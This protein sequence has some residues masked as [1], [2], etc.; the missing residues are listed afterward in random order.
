MIRNIRIFFA[1]LSISTLTL[2]CFA[3]GPKQIKTIEVQSGRNFTITL[4]ANATTGYQWQFSRP[5]DAEAIQLIS[6]EYIADKTG[7]TGSGGKQVW[8][9]KALKSGKSSIV[10]QYLRP[11]EKDNPPEKEEV[12]QVIVK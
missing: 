1:I 10:F 3:Q 8:V 6:S 4:E 2:N 7:L 12:F 5:L 9:F 11:W